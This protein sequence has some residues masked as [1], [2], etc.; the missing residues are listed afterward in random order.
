MNMPR[1]LPM[2]KPEDAGLSPGRLSRI[3]PALQSYMDRRLAPG[4]TFLVARRGK[5]ALLDAM[6]RRDVE[7]GAPAA[8]DT[9]YRIASMTKPIT[10]VALM[11]LFDEGRF[12]LSDPIMKWLPEFSSPLVAARGAASKKAGALTPA[13]APAPAD[14]PITFKH[15]LTHT[16]GLPATLDQR[17]ADAREHSPDQP[18][19]LSDF[20]KRYAKLPLN[21]HPGEAWEYSRATCVAG[22]L[23]EV[24][25]GSTLDAFFKERIF[26]PLGM[27]DTHFFLP[28]E[29]LGR[30]AA[31]YG[32][33]RG[34]ELRLVDPPSD[35]SRF[36]KEPHA[37]FM[38]S[39]GLV[40]TVTDYFRF[41]QMMLNRGE[42][43][44][45]RILNKE[46]V[47]LMTRSHTGDLP[48]PLAGPTMGFGLGYAVE[49]GGEG[50][51]GAGIDRHPWSAGSY[52][53]GGAYCTHQ[54][55]DPRKKIIGIIMTQVRPYF[56]LNV[57]RDFT[58]L[59][60]E[61]VM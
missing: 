17:N 46:T 48:I 26:E 7:T 43:D 2:T 52:A 39:G 23:V 33:G 50:G 29:K 44:G 53:W 34:G 31:A 58:D 15:I 9:I 36:V 41:N 10:S 11:T 13:G 14:T 30:F 49:L 21:F 37:F 24:I 8:A 1:N 18:E 59:V 16:A 22:R 51:A 47:D 57:F 35:D 60:H 45:E 40:S 28:L 20:V 19:T 38:G 12:S 27:R 5:V 55:V 25:S 42:L 56:H 6:G 54:W 32:P 4:F 61:A 3:R